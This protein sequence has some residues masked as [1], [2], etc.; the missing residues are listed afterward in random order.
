VTRIAQ[1][2]AAAGKAD[3]KHER[4]LGNGFSQLPKRV[5]DS[6]RYVMGGG[7]FPVCDKPL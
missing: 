1:Q 7:R 3:A 2:S 5:A 6:V 4:G